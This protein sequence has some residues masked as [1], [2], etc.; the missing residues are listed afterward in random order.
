MAI[1]ETE[2]P[3]RAFS[4][5]QQNATGKPDLYLTQV[6]RGT[7]GGEYLR[8][9]W[10]AIAFEHEVKDLPMRTKVLGEDLVLFRDKSGRYGVMHLHCC[11]RGTSLEYGQIEARGIRCCYHGRL[12]DIDGTTIEAPGE[13]PDALAKFVQG[14]YPTHVHSGLIFVYMGPPELQPAFALYDR[15]D[16]KGVRTAPVNARLPFSC[17]WVQVKENSMDPIHTATL[18]VLPGQPNPFGETFGVVPELE[19]VETPVG[20][21]YLAVRRVG[22]NIW[23]RSTDLLIPTIHSI[24]SVFETGRQRKPAAPPWMTLWTTPV[25][26]GS[27]VNFGMMHL[28]GDETAEKRNAGNFNNFGQTADRPYEERQRVPGDWDAMSSQWSIHQRN[29]ENLGLGD[30]GVVMFR[31]LLRRAIEA[32]E[33]GEDPPFNYRRDGRMMTTYGTDQ[34]LPLSALDGDPDDPRALRRHA[35]SVAR[36]YLESPPLQALR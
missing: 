6:G 27:C 22:D 8:R 35:Q 30:R 18:H 17:N 3:T 23:T 20:M 15:F 26:D 32:V 9:F 25:D 11:H 29:R 4:G 24:T 7:P 28:S 19:F 14:A 5:Y 2:T 13:P 21:I 10:H 31:R 12:Y 16:L 1:T 36:Q 34:V 33:R